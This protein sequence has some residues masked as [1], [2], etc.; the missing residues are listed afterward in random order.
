MN[1]YAVVGLGY[2]GL[3]LAT[4]FAQKN[5]T[6]GYDIDERRIQELREGRDRND[7]IDEAT[8]KHSNNNLYQSS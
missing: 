3:G 8:L 1:T 5:P 7:L 2:V 4:A 6:L